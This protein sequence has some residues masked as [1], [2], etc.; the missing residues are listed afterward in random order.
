MSLRLEPQQRGGDQVL[1]ARDVRLGVGGRTLLEGL[2]AYIRRG[3]V[4]GL[5]GAN[6]AG[7]STLLDAI[8]GVRPPERGELR[9]GAS[10]QVAYY[11]QDMAQIP[12]G[13]S[14]FDIVY[15]LRPSWD[16]GQVQAHLGRFGFP[17]ETVQRTADRLSGGERA[18]VGL[19]ILMLSR[20]NFLLLD[21]PTNHLD[22]ESVEALE[23]LR[24]DGPPRQPRPGPAALP[25]DAGVGDR[26]G[27]RVG[28]P[29]PVHR[30][31]GS[32]AEARVAASK[33][34]AAPPEGEPESAGS[35]PCAAARAAQGLGGMREADPRYRG[36]PRIDRGGFGRRLALRAS[37]GDRPGDLD[38]A[39]DGPDAAT[40][41]GRDGPLDPSR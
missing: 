25:D 21:E 39:G 13:R 31:G 11:R 20:A 16:R 40:P 8:A 6:G 27:S 12:S 3:E 37:R 36:A 38:E 23:D 18:R 7:K 15:D 2:D 19:A 28:L 33:T 22:V 10:I 30:V 14:L 9:V 35:R 26:G 29:R 5:V 41:P 17:G 34:E 24:R 32:M 1:V 4:V